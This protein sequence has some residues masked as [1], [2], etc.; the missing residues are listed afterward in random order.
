[1]ESST[2]LLVSPLGSLDKGRL[3]ENRINDVDVGTLLKK[4]LARFCISTA[5]HLAQFNAQGLAFAFLHRHRKVQ[6]MPIICLGNRR[7]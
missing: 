3:S 4:L 5:G 2:N 1:M 6:R 7:N